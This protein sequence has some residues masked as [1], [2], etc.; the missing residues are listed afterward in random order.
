[1]IKFRPEPTI[2]KF[3]LSTPAHFIG[4]YLGDDFLITHAFPIS[5]DSRQL[6]QRSLEENFISRHFYVVI[7]ETLPVD[8][9]KRTTIFPDYASYGEFFTILL[10]ILFGKKFEGHGFFET[11]GFY[12][13]PNFEN[14][15]S[16]NSPKLPFNNQKVREN[17]SIELN[18]G[19]FSNVNLVMD[20]T[21][22][23]ERLTDF[24]WSAGKFYIAGI[25]NFEINPAFSFLNFIT[26]G[27]ILSNYYLFPPEDLL[28]D[29]IKETFK[30][31]A[32]SITDGQ[33][34]VERMRSRFFQ[35]K[36]K[37][38]KTIMM[39]L[40]P[41]F[42]NLIDSKASLYE[43][44]SETDFEKRIKA[45]Y[46]L[47]SRFV[48]TGITIDHWLRMGPGEV[49]IGMPVVPDK[50]L[51][52]LLFLSPTLLGL[53]RIMRYCILKLVERELKIKFA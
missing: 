50:E 37:F 7:F 41:D 17:Y 35:V 52:N 34:I 44:L 33:K 15:Y 27:E 29:E 3:F 36:R 10:S 45:A 38:I 4:E 16:F 14:A 28:D 21:K 43:R 25:Q 2:H 24:L 23:P 5:G 42:F 1:M 13:V 47:R 22:C 53:E 19:K 30:I 49:M 18:L 6:E 39:L 20:P 46:D 11:N 9:T 40:E 26:C 48:H 31:I 32:E 51:G 12:N 8:K